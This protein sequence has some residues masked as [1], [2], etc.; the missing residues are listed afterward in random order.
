M[1][2]VRAVQILSEEGVGALSSYS[3]DEEQVDTSSHNQSEVEVASSAMY[4]VCGSSDTPSQ[5]LSVTH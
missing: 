3:L 4:S 2:S 5:G 1:H